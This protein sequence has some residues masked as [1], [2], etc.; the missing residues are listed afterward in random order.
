MKI[1]LTDLEQ[2]P[3]TCPIVDDG[4]FPATDLSL[5]D[6]PRGQITAALTGSAQVLLE[7]TMDCTVAAACDRCCKPAR[8][9]RE[10]HE[11]GHDAS[12]C[13]WEDYNRLYLKEPVID[14]GEL[15]REQVYLSMPARILCRESCR[16]LCQICGADLNHERCDCEKRDGDSPFAVLRRLK[17]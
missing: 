16:G 17:K 2:S 1:V 9:G 8:L 14:V 15:L 11:S 4:W 5:A 13:R 3:A 6:G 7:G 12:E 10:E